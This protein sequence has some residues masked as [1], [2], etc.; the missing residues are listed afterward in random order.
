VPAEPV[1]DGLVPTDLR[2]G[3]EGVL[4]VGQP[5]VQQ[6]QPVQDVGRLTSAEHGAGPGRDA[7]AVAPFPEVQ[8]LHRECAPGRIKHQSLEHLPIRVVLDLAEIDR[9]GGGEPRPAADLMSAS[10]A[11]VASSGRASFAGRCAVA[12]HSATSMS[13]V[14]WDASHSSARRDKGAQRRSLSSARTASKPK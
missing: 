11:C 7:G 8:L 2:V 4:K 3:A 6:R 14:V 12:N 9:A 13:S 10:L 1:R 5:L